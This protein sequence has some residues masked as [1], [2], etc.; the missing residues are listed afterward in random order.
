[1]KLR[2]L[3]SILLFSVI[4]FAQNGTVSGVILDKE[5]NNEPLPFAN[6]MIKGSP[7]GTTTD[8]NGKYSLALKPGNYTIIF[9]Y[10]GYE[11]KEIAFSL[12]ANEKKIINHTL[13][14]SGVQLKDIEIIQV[15]SK[16][17]E[18]AL[19]QEQLKAVEIKQSIGAQEMSRKG[20]S[21]VE[22]GLTKV[23][24]ITKV[25]SR[26]LFIRGLEDRYNNLLINNLAVPSNSPFKK[27]I[28]LDLFPTDIVGYMDIFKTFNPNIYGDFAGA[29]I[30]INTTEPTE[31]FTKISYG[32]GYVS[33]NNMRDF[34][35]SSDADNTKS[36]F[37]FGGQERELPSGFGKTPNGQINNDFESTWNVNKTSSPLNTSFGFTH[38]NKFDVGNKPY[39]MYY[40]ISANFDN[41]YQFREGIQRTFQTGQGIY[42]NN[43]TTSQYKFGTQA[44]ALFSLNF[45]SDRLKITT[46]SLFIKATQS[47]IQDQFGYTRNNVQNPNEIIR[48]NQYDESNYFANQIQSEYKIT[49]DGKHLLKGGLSYTRTKF[50]QPDRKFIN[51]TKVNQEDIEVRFGSNNLIRQFLDVENNFH[52]SGLME[53]N[54]KFGKNEDKINK[55][56]LGYNG[57]AEYMKT[58]YRFIAGLPNNA[59]LPASIVNLNNI[60]SF[61]QN[62]IENNNIS[63]R[64]ET[65]GEYKTKIFNRVDGFYG[66]ITYNITPKLELNAGIRAENTIRDLK[67]RTI[68]DPIGSEYRKIETNQ[69]D[70]LPSLNLKYTASENK[71]IRLAASRTITRPVLFESLPITYINADGTSEKG[72]ALLVNSTNNNLDLKFEIFPTK[73]ELFA[74]TAFGKYIE[75]PIER[76]FDNFGGGSGQQVSY[77]NNKSATLFGLEFESII[78][79]SRLNENLKGASF[80]FNTSVMHTEA[81][82]E[83]DRSSQ[84]GTYFDTFDKRQ[85]QGASNWLVNADLKYEFKFSEKWKNTTTLVYGVYGERIYAVGIAGLDHVYEKPFHKLDFIWSQNINK[86][87]DV[88]MSV[89]NILNPYY[90]RV[91]GDES[92]I[93]VTE[94]SLTV[95]SFK[96]GTGFSL[97]ASYKF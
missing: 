24:G 75:N 80:G 19:L 91:M 9:G 21:N 93:P 66:N 63:F 89:D 64:E 15:V 12:K 58:S 47:E 25:E 22:T 44:S 34:L 56:A 78:Q 90:E 16:E 39:R 60:D 32:V 4:S 18:S 10:L 3:F 83:K 86:K 2:L 50:N 57:Y 54:Y 5:M 23:T 33:N 45:K 71:N 77:Y 62:A 81:T 59:N 1:M 27:I 95:Q 42:D 69:L 14:A 41:K 88:K 87:W 13:E 20:I 6:V 79:L 76:S 70:I 48:L 61:I 68:S 26:G 29:T 31:S 40:F 53:Y 30:D 72:N 46:N 11:N 97:G 17:K 96:R 84:N 65:G 55:I 52:M 74:I 28:P 85:L 51:G 38:A 82:A 92:L 8:E 73:D 35:I 7:Q 43:F 37:G 67:Y 94:N 36:F 49:K